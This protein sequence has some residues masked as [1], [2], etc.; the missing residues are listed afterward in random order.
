MVYPNPFPL[1]LRGSG[2][3]FSGL[4]LGASLDIFTLD[5]RLVNHLE[6]TPG[7]GTLLW[8]GQNAAGFLAGSGI[9]LF[10]AMDE[11]GNIVRGKFA[12]INSR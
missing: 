2:L 4:P 8:N 7:Q 9:Y 5:G 3:T 12:V 1:G 10:V 6:G 11:T